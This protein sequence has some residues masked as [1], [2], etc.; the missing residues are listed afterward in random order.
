M[1]RKEKTNTTPVPRGVEIGECWKTERFTPEGNPA[2]TV[3]QSA[4]HYVV[5]YDNGEAEIDRIEL[6]KEF[7]DFIEEV[8]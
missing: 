2:Y 5:L 7:L 8:E 3:F 6:S 4:T 1:M